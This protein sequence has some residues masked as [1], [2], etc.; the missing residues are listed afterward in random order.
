MAFIRNKKPAALSNES[1][2]LEIT[3]PDELLKFAQ[4]KGIQLNPLDVSRL[5]QSLGIIMRMQPMQGDE[6][7][8]LKKDKKTGEWIIT[9]NSLHHPNRQRFTIAH[10]LGHYIKHSGLNDTFEDKVFFRN[11]ETNNLEIEAN[12]FAAELLMPE[13]L[14][15]NYTSTTSSDISDIANEFGVSSMAV[16]V[17]AKQLGYSGH[18]L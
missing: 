8:S 2:H 11:G 5:T 10:E 9:V 16:R 3:G 7:G 17:R 1:N 14:F 12:R 4:A 18:N 13:I 15:R 6:S